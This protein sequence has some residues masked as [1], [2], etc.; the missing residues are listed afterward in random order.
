MGSAP[1]EIIFE[2]K[3]PE[4]YGQFFSFASDCLRICGKIIWGKNLHQHRGKQ[5][6]K[7]R[8][9]NDNWDVLPQEVVCP[10][11]RDLR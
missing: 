6:I 3:P 5:V 2:K 10:D 1:G 9:Q 8:D 7:F 4:S 11:A